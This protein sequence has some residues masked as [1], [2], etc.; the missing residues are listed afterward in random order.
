LELE[1]HRFYRAASYH[2]YYV[3][4]ELL[5]AHGVMVV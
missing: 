4:R 3:L 2:V 5:P 1:V